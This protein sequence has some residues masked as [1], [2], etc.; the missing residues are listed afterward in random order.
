VNP[1]RVGLF[2]LCALTVASV[3]DHLRGRLGGETILHAQG[4]F[5]MPDPKQMSG[6]PRPVTDLPDRAISVRVIR[7]SLSNNIANQPVELRV[8]SKTLTAKTDESGRAQFNEVTAGEMVRATTTVDGERLESQE[9]PVPANGGIRLMLVAT[10]TSKGPATEPGAPPVTG[11]VVIGN[12]SRVVVQPAEEAV[13][14]YY[15]L[16][17]E[18]S[19]RTPVNT[20]KSFVFNLPKGA[21]GATIMEGS[22]PQAALAGNQVLVKEPFA[23]GATFVQVAYE[24]AA[25]D[26]T[27]AVT[28]VFPANFEQLSVIVKKV[29]DTGISSPQIAT[30]REVPAEGE[31]YIAASG[32]AIA[33]GQ[34]LQLAVTGIP[35]HNSAPRWVALVLAGG[36]LLIGVWASGRG[37]DTRSAAA[38]ERKRLTAKRDKLLN[39]LVRLEHDRRHGRVDD[40]RYTARREELIGTLEHVYGSLDV[41]S[42]GPEPFDPAGLAA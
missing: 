12:Q 20:P 16:D 5:Q 19:A 13:D 38:T 17:I 39:D 26:G 21:T 15:L 4:G 14:V 31:T 22:S 37:A 40:R 33:A 32:G 24:L 2:V 10:D 35:H 18:N 36:I 41:S 23:P 3:P 8:G 30:E 25:G 7:G 6:I 27:A 11:I 29:G 9:F 42:A 28:Q 34:P 1:R